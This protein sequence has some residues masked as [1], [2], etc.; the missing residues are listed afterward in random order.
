MVV[1]IFM[2]RDAAGLLELLHL[3]PNLLDNPLS[4]VYDLRLYF[5]REWLLAVL[6]LKRVLP[7]VQYLAIVSLI[8]FSE[9]HGFVGLALP[10]LH[11]ERARD[12]RQLVAIVKKLRAPLLRAILLST[13]R[14]LLSNLA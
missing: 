7:E 8:Y 5:G 11:P 14:H 12:G 6:G 13:E 4:L 9:R 1:A 2:L 3:G 10:L